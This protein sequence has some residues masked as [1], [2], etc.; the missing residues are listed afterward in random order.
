MTSD[1]VVIVVSG[2]PRTDGRTD[3]DDDVTATFAFSCF[4]LILLRVCPLLILDS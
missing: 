3:V 1:V 2:G 4:F